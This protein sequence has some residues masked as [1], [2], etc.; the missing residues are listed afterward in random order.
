MDKCVL[1]NILQLTASSD[2]DADDI[3]KSTVHRALNPANGQSRY[4]IPLFFGTDYAV[5]L[6]V[7]PS[8]ALL[9]FSKLETAQPIPGCVSPE[10]PAR[11]PVTTAGEHV[12]AKFQATYGVGHY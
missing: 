3:F 1:H 2:Y 11:Y 10:R 4:S 8:F 9:H 12:K 7:R 5:P 6:D